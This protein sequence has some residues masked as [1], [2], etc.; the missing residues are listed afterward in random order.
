MKLDTLFSQVTI[1]AFRS[2]RL[3]EM[4][5]TERSPLMDVFRAN[6]GRW[7]H[8]SQIPKLGINPKKSHDDPVGIYFYPVDFLLTDFHRMEDGSQF[9]LSWPYYFLCDLDL[10]APGLTLS[11]TTAA[12]VTALAERNG[13]KPLL[14]A[15][16]A[17]P[18]DERAKM[19]TFHARQGHL[20]PGAFLWAF[21]DQQQ[22]EKRITWNRALKGLAYVRDDG[23]KIIHSYEPDQIV[24]FDPR[25]IKNATIHENKAGDSLQ[26]HKT[27]K[28]EAWVHALKKIFEMTA[29]E[30]GGA[31]AWNKKMPELHLRR[32]N[33]TFRFYF[34]DFSQ[35][36]YCEFTHGRAKD[37]KSTKI[38]DRKVADVA[39]ELVGWVDE[40]IARDTDLTWTPPLSEDDARYQIAHG[41]MASAHDLVFD[42][43]VNNTYSKSLSV[44]ADYVNKRTK[45][46]VVDTRVAMFIREEEIAET[47]SCRV[48]DTRV[49]SFSHVPV[50]PEDTMAALVT[51]CDEFE[52]ALRSRSQFMGPDSDSWRRRSF[53]Y[54]DDWAAF[55]GW[56][57]ENCGVSFNGLLH[58]RF[59]DEI[60]AYRDYSDKPYLMKQIQEVMAD[61]R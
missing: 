14:D 39:R 26:S 35:T 53:R 47:V 29:N 37:S 4:S 33:C 17:A 25:I 51:L 32:D 55:L 43:E 42:T 40:V 5:Y 13:W 49:V 8:F 28:K 23:N 19:L 21:L 57:V 48:N 58:E 7:I 30:V 59:A 41:V 56:F 61:H 20:S 3:D 18:E 2:R 12:D 16:E 1:P 27:D 22:K 52:K 46:A 36:I 10:S 38:R 31:I 50:D 45:R 15:Y 11:S 6:R 54:R 24:V 9:G 34:S 44:T 60:A